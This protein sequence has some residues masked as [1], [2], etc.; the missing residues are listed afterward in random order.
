MLGKDTSI[1]QA[2]WPSVDPR[3]L[4]EDEKLVVLQVNGKL[5]AKITVA[6]DITQADLQALALQDPQIQSFIA[7]KEVRKVIVVPG[8]LVNIV[9]S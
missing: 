8:K 6:A 1:E 7:G 2:G 5:R 3:A 4:V 9:V